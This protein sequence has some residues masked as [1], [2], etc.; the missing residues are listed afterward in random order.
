MCIVSFCERMC[1]TGRF[2]PASDGEMCEVIVCVQ[3]I[4]SD[5]EVHGA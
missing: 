2:R 3:S 1:E 4:Y 5:G